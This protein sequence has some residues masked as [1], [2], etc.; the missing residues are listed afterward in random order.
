MRTLTTHEPSRG[1]ARHFQNAPAHPRGAPRHHGHRLRGERSRGQDLTIAEAWA[2]Q[3]RP[4]A[5]T[6]FQ[7][8][9][10]RLPRAG[11]HL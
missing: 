2:T 4:S 5:A 6:T 11:A 7:A 8:Q 10:C 3:R 9:A 1:T